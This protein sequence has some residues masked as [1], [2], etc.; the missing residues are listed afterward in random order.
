MKRFW[1][2]LVE[3]LASGLRSRYLRKFLTMPTALTGLCLIVAFT[4]VAALAPVIASPKHPNYPYMIPR[5]SY[6]N[7]PTPPGPDHVLGTTPGQYDILY[8]LVWGTST[9][10][11]VGLLVT[12]SVAIIGVAIGSISA[13]YGCSSRGTPPTL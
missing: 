12:V 8:G 3:R 10:F 7:E 4:V 1:R 6:V 2:E 5:D 11:R 13:F 9:A